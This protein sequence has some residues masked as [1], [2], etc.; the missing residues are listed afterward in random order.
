MAEEIQG[1][2]IKFQPDYP[3]IS[4]VSIEKQGSYPLINGVGIEMARNKKYQVFVDGV[5]SLLHMD[6][7]VAT[8]DKGL[9]VNLN[10]SNKFN[11]FYTKL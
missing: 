5:F 4:G 7:K 11:L 6:G 2:G 1:I 3:I 8:T 10:Q 9:A